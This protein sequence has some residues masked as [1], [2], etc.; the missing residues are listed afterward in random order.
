MN[1]WLYGEGGYYKKIGQVGKEGDFLTSP[2]VSMFFGGCLANKYLSLVQS[3]KL[4]KNSVVCEFGANNLYALKDFASFLAGLE[5]SLLKSAKFVVVERQSEVAAAQREELCRFFDGV[6]FEI[7]S[8]LDG[9]K[10]REAF[11]FANEIFDSFACELFFD[12]QIGYVNNSKIEFLGETDA[13]ALAY[14]KEF[15]VNK[16][17]IALG[18]EE[19]AASLYEAF[20]KIYF[21]TFDYGAEYARGDFSARIYSKHETIPLFAEG[22]L[23]RFFG[24]CDIT[25]DV[26]FAH[27][28]KAFLSAGYGFDGYRSQARALMDF[29]IV[30]LL[31]IY[32]QK[33][34]EEAFKKESQKALALMAPNGFGERFKQIS[35]T[36]GF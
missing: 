8:S 27:L 15:G 33:A 28:K 31:S 18:Y 13:A 11:V 4:S 30:D 16:G 9:F 17:E 5:P 29:G 35:F 25:Y 32:M 23:E 7:V 19:F 26:N 2:S 34:G 21:C 20:S 3:G 6:D 10:D 14:S 36:K 24:V 1:S 12:G 22:D